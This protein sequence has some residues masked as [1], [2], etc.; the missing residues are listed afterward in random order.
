MN[1]IACVCAVM[2]AA[3]PAA[4]IAATLREARV[5]VVFSPHACDVTSRFVLD[6]PEPAIVEHRVML[7]DG[8]ASRF[9]VVGALAGDA[10]IVGRTARVPISITGAGRNEYTVRYSVAFPASAADRCPLLVPSAPTDGLSRTA[11]I[12]V[13]LPQRA[14]RLPGAFPAFVWSDGRGSVAIAHVPSFVRVPHVAA[15]AAVRWRD[16]LDIRRAIDLAA[17]LLIATS[18]LA[19]AAYQRRSA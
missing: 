9:A 11:R 5:T 10:D 1:R 12:E 2:V 6:T 14:T 4:A 16:T 3:L 8:R 7:S 13:E 17:I 15:G 19:W 18:T